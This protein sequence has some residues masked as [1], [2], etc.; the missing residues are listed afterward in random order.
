MIQEY[1]TD[2]KKYDLFT[3]LGILVGKAG[4][5]QYKCLSTF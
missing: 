4:H 5:D 1:K 3:W 2:I